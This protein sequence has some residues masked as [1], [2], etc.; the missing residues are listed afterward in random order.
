MPQDSAV[1]MVLQIFREVPSVPASLLAL[2]VIV[3]GAL[4]LGGRAVER[5]EYV[6]DQ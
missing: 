2:A 5:R 4:W 6:L 1:S 3:A